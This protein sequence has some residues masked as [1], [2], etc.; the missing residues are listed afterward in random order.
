M[1]ARLII[2]D[3]YGPMLVGPP[4][5]QGE[6][7]NSRERKPDNRRPSLELD[8][9]RPPLEPDQGEQGEKKERK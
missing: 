2:H 9:R 1:E 4:P 3:K 5:D 7:K 8:N 6:N